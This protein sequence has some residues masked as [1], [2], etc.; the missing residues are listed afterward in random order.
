LQPI[1]GATEEQRQN[2]TRS[3]A[4]DELLLGDTWQL[5]I[6]RPAVLALNSDGPHVSVDGVQGW[7]NSKLTGGR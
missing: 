1:I 4:Y 3:G 2:A 5:E 7:R 6:E